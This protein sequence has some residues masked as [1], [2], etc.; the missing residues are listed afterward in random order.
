MASF[1]KKG[2]PV[3]LEGLSAHVAG[4]AIDVA[5]PLTSVV[6]RGSVVDL[7]LAAPEEAAAA[8]AAAPEEEE[9]EPA[10]AAAAPEEEEAEAAP[11]AAEKRDAPT[12]RR[13][14]SS[15]S[16]CSRP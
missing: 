10:A 1:R 2:L 6:P 11:P 8:A 16:R 4:T 5:A 3:G 9:E 12:P 13:A 7:R 15:R 14:S